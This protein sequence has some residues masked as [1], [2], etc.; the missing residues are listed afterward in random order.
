M[1][2]IIEVNQE[3]ISDI[4]ITSEME[5][6]IKT[7]LEE[8][9]AGT[10]SLDDLTKFIFKNEKIDGRNKEGRT[11]R[12]W[13]IDNGITFKTS[14]SEKENR[15]ELLNEHK[16]FIRSN[17]DTMRPMEMARVLWP[18][19]KIS[20]LHREY[21][22]LQTYIQE[23]KPEAMP[24]SD[25][26]ADGPYIAPQ[27]IYRLVPKINSFISKYKIENAKPLPK[28]EKL[29]SERDVK[30]LKAL[31]GYLNTD[32]YVLSINIYALVEEREL[33]ESKFIR[34]VY[35]KPDLTE[36]EVDQY[37]AV[38][39]KSVALHQIRRNIQVLQREINLNLES[40]DAEKKKVAMSYIELLSTYRQ[41]ETD[42]EKR[43]NDTLEGLV[44]T[45]DKRLKGRLTN[46][47][48]IMNLVVAWQTEEKRKELLELAMK[49]RAAEEDAVKKLSSMDAVMALVAGF[50]TEQAANG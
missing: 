10:L 18:S 45:R 49:Q 43:Q 15:F 28:E 8:I 12:K 22:A 37:I 30:Y 42:A 7:R 32:V 3:Q 14:K 26:M 2:D 40:G 48:T 23:L 19:K 27:S 25:K 39:D 29:L 20:P 9:F 34:Y 4:K 47:A 16:E 44:G 21:L 17:I 13:L 5:V 46:N 11:L 36:E 24:S 50:S 41:K 6:V 1:N 33:F 35:D 31:L 38:C